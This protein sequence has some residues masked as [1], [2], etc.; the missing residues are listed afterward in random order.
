M[1][2]YRIIV[3][4]SAFAFARSAV[5]QGATAV[6]AKPAAISVGLRA[7][8]DTVKTGDPVVLKET[9]TNRSD[10][11]MRFGVDVYH[12]GC[13]ADVLDASGNFA[14]DR[15]LGYHRGRIDYTGLSDAQILQSGLLRGSVLWI[16]LKPGETYS[17]NSVAISDQYDMTKPGDYTITI[18]CSVPGP[19][20]PVTAKSGAI[21]V[22]VTN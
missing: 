4:A 11:E 17:D 18:E 12:P 8:H 2:L 16:T 6:E 14:P 15:R 21:K 3:L 20:G 22:T 19:T 9:I 5:S 10:H 1:T 13:G 7:E